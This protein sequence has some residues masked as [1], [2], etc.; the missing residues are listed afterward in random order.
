V[1]SEGSGTRVGVSAFD[2][3]YMSHLQLKLEL[4]SPHVIGCAGSARGRLSLNY[5]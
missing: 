3:S 4:P 1:A 2:G 5:N